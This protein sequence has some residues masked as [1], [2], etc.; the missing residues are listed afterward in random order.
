MKNDHE[1]EKKQNL[2]R[3]SIFLVLSFLPDIISVL[4]IWLIFKEPL[5]ASKNY[6]V[7][8]L[9]YVFGILGMMAPSTACLLTRLLTKEGFGNNYLDIR[10]K[11]NA[12]YWI[13]PILVKFLEGWVYLPVLWFL[14]M[15]HTSLSAAYP[16]FNAVSIASYLHQICVVFLC[17]FSPFG[18]EWGWRGYMMPKLLKLMPKPAAVILGGII[19][20]LWH[21]PFTITGHNFGI[22]YPGFPYLGIRL[23]CLVC[24]V[25]NA[26]LTLVTEKTG[27]VFPATFI[28]GINNS[29]SVSIL[30]TLFASSSL[31]YKV[32]S[33]GTI[34]M[35]LIIT[36]IPAI[37]GI[38]SLILFMK[39]R[40]K[41][42]NGDGSV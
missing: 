27:S 7:T 25:N 24:V 6:R 36:I 18:E 19:W 4:V 13:I 8:Q 35:T 28:H 14:F 1:N 11:G 39:K 30:L 15:R 31:R 10:I 26:F 22:N 3:L 17:F 33:A 12:G 34:K 23:M 9:A 37:T 21:A 2:L 16:N 38:V 29:L 41:C 40:V 42:V 20:G 5:F 32:E